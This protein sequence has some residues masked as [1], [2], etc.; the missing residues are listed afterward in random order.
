MFVFFISEFTVYSLIYVQYCR[1]LDVA[2]DDGLI[3]RELVPTTVPM[4][5]TKEGCNLC[6]FIGL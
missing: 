6:M 5:D 3:E 1:W 2:E 4:E